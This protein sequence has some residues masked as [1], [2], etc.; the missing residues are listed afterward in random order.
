MVDGVS[1]PRKVGR[2][3]D[4]VHH[5]EGT[6]NDLP[7][8]R[9]VE[10]GAGVERETGTIRGEVE[11][12][13][14]E[15]DYSKSDHRAVRRWRPVAGEDDLA[16]GRR[17]QRH[18]DGGPDMEPELLL[19]REAREGIK[20]TNRHPPTNQLDG[21]GRSRRWKADDC[22]VAPGQKLPVHDHIAIGIERAD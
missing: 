2:A 9:V 18:G 6:D 14:L 15:P 20:R 3:V 19:H 5:R 16:L 21:V 4:E 1:E 22:Q 13:R 12:A 11:H 17:V 10:R 8:D 7:P